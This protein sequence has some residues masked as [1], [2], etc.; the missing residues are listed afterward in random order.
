VLVNPIYHDTVVSTA[1]HF[2]VQSAVAQVPPGPLHNQVAASVAAQ[3]MQ[4]AQHL[5]DQVFA[6]LK[7]SLAYA[8]QHGFIAVLVICGAVIVATFFFKD[9]PMSQQSG[10]VSDETEMLAGSEE[11]MSIVP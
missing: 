11:G 6:V 2:A 1:Q 4:Q 3:A 7:L 8:I 9:V 10:E 5:L